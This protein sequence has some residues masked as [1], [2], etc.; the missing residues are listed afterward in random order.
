MIRAGVHEKTKDKICHFYSNLRTEI[1]DIVDYNKYNTINC[2]FLFYVGR[3]RI[4]GSPNNENENLLHAS[5]STYGSIQNC[6]A[7]WSSFLGDTFSFLC[8]FNVVDTFC[9]STPHYGPE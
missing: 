3:K 8:S 1:Q 5:F 2:L 9:S 7:F 6:Y 4:A